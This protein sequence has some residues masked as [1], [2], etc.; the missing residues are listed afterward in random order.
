MSLK[1]RIELLEKPIQNGIPLIIDGGDSTTVEEARIK[2]EKETGFNPDNYTRG[3]V[4]YIL[5]DSN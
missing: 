4:I 2:Y 3:K 1:T 5:F